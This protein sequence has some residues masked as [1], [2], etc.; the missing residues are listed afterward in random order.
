MDIE[1]EKVIELVFPDGIPGKF[2]LTADCDSSCNNVSCLSLRNN[3]IPTLFNYNSIRRFIFPLTESWK[4]NPDFYQYLT[5]LGGFDVDQL[6]KPSIFLCRY[7]LKFFGIPQRFLKIIDRL[8]SDKEPDHLADE[9]NAVLQNT[10]E[11]AFSNYKTFIQTAESSREIFYQVK[12][13][14][15]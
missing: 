9:K 3:H 11:L 6:S 10:Q 5:K 13:C 8:I 7:T 15:D 4:E 2:N 12:D 1:T 14:V